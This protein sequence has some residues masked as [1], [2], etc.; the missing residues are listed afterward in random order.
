M[1]PNL[2]T[3]NWDKAD[4]ADLSRLIEDGNVDIFYTSTTNIHRV[5]A[6]YFLHQ[7]KRTSV[8]TFVTLLLLLPLR[9]NSAV[10]GG[11]DKKVDCCGCC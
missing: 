4:K 7:E 6:T 5:G 9:G 1:M 11:G 2:P 10:Q 8:A 3:K